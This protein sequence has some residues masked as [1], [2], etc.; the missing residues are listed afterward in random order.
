MISVDLDTI[1]GVAPRLPSHWTET[2]LEAAIYCLEHNNHASGVKIEVNDKDS[3][4]IVEWKKPVDSKVRAMWADH[5]VA[6]E[7]GA[8]GVAAVM[9]KAKTP[10]TILRRSSKSTGIDYWL[11]DKKSKKSVSN[12][13]LLFQ[14]ESA[15]LEVSGLMTGT[16]SQYNARVKKKE[17]QTQRSA[18]TGL[19]A[20]VSVTDFGRPRT[21]FKKV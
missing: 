15:R 13:L 14:D 9:A 17:K 2:R 11:T 12:S 1:K 7:H 20:Y 18:N 5:D 8:E 10:Y 3:D 21:T 4:H 6:A 19:P 16:N